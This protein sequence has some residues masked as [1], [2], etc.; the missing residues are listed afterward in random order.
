MQTLLSLL[1]P[2]ALLFAAPSDGT[3]PEGKRGAKMQ[4]LDTDGSGTLSATE[5]EG[6]RIAEHF[7]EI[8]ANGDG[9]LTR[10]EMR[11]AHEARRGEHEGKCEGKGKGKGKGKGQGKRGQH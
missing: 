1:V 3:R 10:D 9:E 6:T 5:V 7:A 4:R 2:A 8:D 11:A